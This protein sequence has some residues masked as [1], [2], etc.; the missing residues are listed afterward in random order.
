MSYRAGMILFAI[1]T[2]GASASSAA[3]AEPAYLAAWGELLEQH[4]QSVTGTVGTTVD[5]AALNSVSNPRWKALVR[6]LATTP[7]PRG[8]SEELALWINAYNVLAIDTVLRNYPVDSI[9]DVGSLFRPVW[10]HEAGTVAGR[11]VSLHEVEHEILRKLREPRIHAAIV[12]ASTSCPSLRRTP[13][14]ADDIEAQLDDAMRRW[15]ASP[16]LA[17]PSL[18]STSLASTSKGLRIDRP[19][20]RISV[21]KIFDWFEED[22]ERIGGVR[23]VVTKYGPESD[24]GWLA[25]NAAGATLEF[26][27]YDWSLNDVR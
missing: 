9:R 5:Y 21:S 2:W 17:S 11:T 26:F 12:C 8:Q 24:R 13:F 27:D 7:A 18:A 23:A 20:K 3:A 4:T 16:S 10:K 6:A 1:V 14:S 15:L 22:F 25:A 19:A